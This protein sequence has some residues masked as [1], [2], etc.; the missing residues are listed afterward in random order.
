MSHYECRSDEEAKQSTIKC[1][2]AAIIVVSGG[3]CTLI[4]GL[5]W[6]SNAEKENK[7]FYIAENLKDRIINIE[8]EI[9]N[10]NEKI[11]FLTSQQNNRTKTKTYNGV[12][13]KLGNPFKGIFHRKVYRKITKPKIPVQVPAEKQPRR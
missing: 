11:Y 1:F 2:I 3:L 5:A 8:D 13:N 6:F 9:T 4:Y 7:A 12:S 10:L